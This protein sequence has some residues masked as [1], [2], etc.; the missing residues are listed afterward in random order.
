M[1]LTQ[2]DEILQ[3]LT[4]FYGILGPFLCTNCQFENLAAKK[5]LRDTDTEQGNSR[6]GEEVSGVAISPQGQ[7]GLLNLFGEKILNEDIPINKA[8]AQAAGPD[9]SQCNSNNR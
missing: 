6:V 1:I 3:N 2:F 8:A 4:C 7:P 9:P 5:N